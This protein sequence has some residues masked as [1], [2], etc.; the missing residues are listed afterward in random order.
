MTVGRRGAARAIS[1]AAAPAAGA[2]SFARYARV[3]PPSW[4]S[5]CFAD[6]SPELDAT[7][8]SLGHH[9]GGASWDRPRSTC[10][11]PRVCG[12]APAAPASVYTEIEVPTLG[13]FLGTPASATTHQKAETVPPARGGELSPR[14][15]RRH[16]RAAGSYRGAGMAAYAAAR[17]FR[18]PR[19]R[20]DRG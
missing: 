6:P 14:I 4:R 7:P 2:R 16:R 9:L 11:A 15:L 8:V 1:S 5:R 13:R 20:P 10:S 3:L 18:G 12:A 17:E 19:A